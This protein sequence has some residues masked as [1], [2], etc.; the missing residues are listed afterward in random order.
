[1]SRWKLH[2]LANGVKIQKLRDSLEAIRKQ[3][4]ESAESDRQSARLHQSC[5]QNLETYFVLDSKRVLRSGD[6][7]RL[8]WPGP[9]NVMCSRSD[10]L[11]D[12]KDVTTNLVTSAHAARL[13]LYH[14]SSL[15]ETEDFPLVHRASKP[16]L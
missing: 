1:M 2:G 4:F 9:Q 11:S 8:R 12:I 15:D 13:R 5:P 10:Y 7:R 14:D 3:A 6:R 16:R